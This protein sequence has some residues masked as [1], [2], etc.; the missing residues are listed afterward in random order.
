MNDLK[1]KKIDKN[2]ALKK[3]SPNKIIRRASRAKL[4]YENIVIASDADFDRPCA[5]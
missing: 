5:G 1:I 3:Y 4:N 2:I